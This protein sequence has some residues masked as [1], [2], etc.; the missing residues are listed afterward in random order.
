MGVPQMISTCSL[1]ILSAGVMSWLAFPHLCPQTLS[2]VENS[3]LSPVPVALVTAGPVPTPGAAPSNRSELDTATPAFGIPRI[4]E[5]LERSWRPFQST[6]IPSLKFSLNT[7]YSC[8][9]CNT[10][11]SQLWVV[12]PDKFSV[13]IYIFVVVF[14][15]H[16]WGILILFF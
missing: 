3:G 7:S 16:L 2:P 12:A 10:V 15:P 13:W 9:G 8:N 11:T 1:V 5:S 4:S 14:V 6:A